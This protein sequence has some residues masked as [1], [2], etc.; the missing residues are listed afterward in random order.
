MAGTPAAHMTA[1]AACLGLPVT[2]LAVCTGPA[3]FS[4]KSPRECLLLLDGQI[5]MRFID[6]N[7]CSGIGRKR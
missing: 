6:K 2:T 3:T 5:D 4:L 1:V 7:I